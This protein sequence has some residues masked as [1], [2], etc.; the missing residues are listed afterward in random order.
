MSVRLEETKKVES[1]Y[2]RDEEKI[3]LRDKGRI[4]ERWVRFF[5]SLQ[6]AKSGKLDPD[7]TTMLPQQPLRECS[8]DRADGREGCPSDEGNSKRESSAAGRPYRGTVETWTTIGPSRL[9]GAPPT[10]NPHLARGKAP[11]QRKDAA[12]AVLHK[13][14]DKTKYGN[15]RG[16][17]LV[18]HGGKVLLRV[19]DRRHS[20]Y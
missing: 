18:S 10:N 7:I 3:L 17:S 1:Q 5:R 13:K 14:G 15:Y 8:W 12:I 19:V 6:N 11:Q 20:H 16:I 2:V 4:R 9:N